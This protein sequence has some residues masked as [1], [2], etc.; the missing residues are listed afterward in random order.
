MPKQGHALADFIFFAH[1]GQFLSGKI[2]D[3]MNKA[4]CLSLISNAILVWNT[5]HIERIVQKLRKEGHVIEDSHLAYISP[6]IF[7]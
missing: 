3:I 2:D 1:R 6:L 4:S 5:T 7:E